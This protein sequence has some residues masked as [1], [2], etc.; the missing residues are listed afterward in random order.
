M[1]FNVTVD[2]LDT[3]QPEFNA[4]AGEISGKIPAALQY[5]GAEMKANLQTHIRLDWYDKYS[6]LAY[7]RRTDN[8]QLGTPLG[9]DENISVIVSGN[10]LNFVY[11]PSGE[12]HDEKG[13]DDWHVR[14]YDELIVWLQHNHDAVQEKE[15][16]SSEEKGASKVESFI[17]PARPFWNY[18]VREQKE[19]GIIAAFRKGMKPYAVVSEAG[20]PDVIFSS[21]ESFLEADEGAFSY[22]PYEGLKVTDFDDELPL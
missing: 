20:N 10:T 15:K 3:I 5:V 16:S 13:N 17:I 22:R 11:L 14:D 18:F 2:G 1:H 8:S 19:G 9:A 4:L 12:W 6:P 21:N 7:E